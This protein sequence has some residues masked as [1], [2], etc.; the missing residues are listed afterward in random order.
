MVRNDSSDI[1][2]SLY[3]DEDVS[4]TVAVALRARGFDVISVREINK[5][6]MNDAEQLKTAVGLNRTLLTFQCV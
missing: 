4:K 5:F 6:G 2:I 1:F 3:L